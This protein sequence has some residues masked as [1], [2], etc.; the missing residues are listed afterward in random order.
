MRTKAAGNVVDVFETVL[1]SYEMLGESMP[2]L[3]QYGKI[4]DRAPMKKLLGQIFQDILEFHREAVKIFKRRGKCS[5]IL[6][7][8][9]LTT[10]SMVNHLC[11]VVEGFW[12][13]I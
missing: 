3:M 10:P 5:A 13:Q 6:L 8:Q 12:Q 9:F 4:L 1:D 2:L 7:S 11:I